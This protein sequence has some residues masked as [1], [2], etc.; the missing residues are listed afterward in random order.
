MENIHNSLF[1]EVL[2]LGVYIKIKNSYKVKE[3]TEMA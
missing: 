2:I 1:S 3:D